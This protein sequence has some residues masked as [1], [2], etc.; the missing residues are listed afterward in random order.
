[1]I[2]IWSY[3][4]AIEC[5]IL[6]CQSCLF[7]SCLLLIWPPLF[8]F[9]PPKLYF[10][11]S[12]R[13]SLGARQADDVQI[14]LWGSYGGPGVGSR[15]QYTCR[16][17]GRLLHL[18]AMTSLRLLLYS[19]PTESFFFTCSV[20]SVLA[21]CLRQEL[22]AN[23]L[24]FLLNICEKVRISSLSVNYIFPLKTVYVFKVLILVEV[25]AIGQDVV[26]LWVSSLCI[27]LHLYIW[28]TYEYLKWIM[29]MT[30]IG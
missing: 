17:R 9:F 27:G 4:N 19:S 28:I 13:H 18:L 25:C 26:V 7:S 6:F 12:N 10:F 2:S 23:G 16:G 5:V 21:P 20:T 24:E 1:M 15:L 30:Y 8:P 22:A 3:L 14:Y 11:T 29:Y